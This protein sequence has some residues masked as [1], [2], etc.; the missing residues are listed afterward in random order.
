MGSSARQK[1]WSL[2]SWSWLDWKGEINFYADNNVTILVFY[3]PSMDGSPI[4]IHPSIRRPE[5]NKVDWA[6]IPYGSNLDD[7]HIHV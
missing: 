4:L 7:A 1:P 5:P 6:D 2:P 3:F